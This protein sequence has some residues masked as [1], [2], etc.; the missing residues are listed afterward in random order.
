[1]AELCYDLLYVNIWW[2]ILNLLPILPLDGGHI[3][4]EVLN[5]CHPRGALQI[6]LWVSLIVATGM[7]AMGLTTKP[8]EVYRILL[9]GMLA[10]SSFQMLSAYSGIR[11]G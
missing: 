3:T 7:A 5:I 2:G 10:Y 4:N 8:V 6:T 1:M 9:F 11:R